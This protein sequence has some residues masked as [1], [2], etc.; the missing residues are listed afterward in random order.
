MTRLLLDLFCGAGGAAMGYHRA[1]FTVVGV[2]KVRQREYPFEFI[3]ADALEYLAEHHTSFSVIHAS[4][5]C[6]G[7]THLNY[8]GKDEHPKLVP[9]VRQALA[10][11]RKVTIIENVPGAPLRSDLVL[12][13]E[14]FG[15]DVQRHRLFECHGWPVAQ[16]PHPKHRG[17]VGQGGPYAGVYGNGGGKG[18]VEQWQ[19]AMGI[20]WVTRRKGLA[21]AIPP[22]Y[23]EF[24]GNQ[25]QDALW[26]RKYPIPR[27]SRP[28][29]GYTPPHGTSPAQG[30]G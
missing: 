18:T 17:R 1:G 11:T 21:Q 12:C 22:A 9:A 16:P 23:T 27:L 28:P 19:Q 13:G 26:R 6:Q 7:Y 3:K 8:E 24:I 4:P 10:D 5:P 2:D 15:L 20:D 25:I 29:K 14:M 30:Q